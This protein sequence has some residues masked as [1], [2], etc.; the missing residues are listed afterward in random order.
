MKDHSTNAGGFTL[1]E[2]CIA[3]VVMMIVGLGATSLFLYSVRSN[4]GG[5]SRSQ[6]LAIAQQRLEALRGV[7]YNA[8]ELSLGTTTTTIVL[9]DITTS[10]GSTTS[11]G[12]VQAYSGTTT[13]GDSSALESG[14]GKTSPTP[15]AYEDDDDDD[16]DDDDDDDDDG[17]GGGDDTFKVVLDIQG[18]PAGSTNPT[19]KRITITVTPENGYGTNSWI[20]KNPVVIVLTRSSP[21]TGPYK[22]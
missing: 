20:N 9:Q 1:I 18:S 19:Q 13:S 2:T 21:I 4:S 10:G 6:A 5:E 3:M 14:S 7:S 22:L 16:G 15:T 8:P 12:G 11:S 17:G